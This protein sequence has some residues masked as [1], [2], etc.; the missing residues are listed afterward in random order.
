MAD[1]LKSSHGPQKREDGRIL[2]L[3]V[4]LSSVAPEI[5]MSLTT[6]RSSFNRM[7]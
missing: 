1:S 4:D 7:F 6:F 2:D 3:G 5:S